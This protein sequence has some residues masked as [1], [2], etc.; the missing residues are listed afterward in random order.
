MANNSRSWTQSIRFRH[1]FSSFVILMIM[2]TC[3]SLDSIKSTTFTSILTDK[4]YTSSSDISHEHHKTT[5]QQGKSS[6]EDTN[7]KW[8]VIH[9]G[10]LIGI[11]RELYL[12][13][14]LS[15]PV[16]IHNFTLKKSLL[17]DVIWCVQETGST[18]SR[19]IGKRTNQE[20]RY[21]RVWN[22]L[23]TQVYRL[24]CSWF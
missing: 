21:I 15:P 23:N 20:Y 17:I 13:N 3:T 10:E 7:S 1:V 16:W 5:I 4:D 2:F 24:C 19:I 11:A 8:R 12:T 9:K 14:I 22:Y 6:S 18:R